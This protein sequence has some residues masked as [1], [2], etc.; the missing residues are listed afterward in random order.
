MGRAKKLLLAAGTL[1]LIGGGVFYYLNSKDHYDPSKYSATITAPEINSQEPVSPI[2]E[3]DAGA[4]TAAAIGLAKGM[5]VELTLPDQFDVS[6]TIAPEIETLI[7]AFSK[8]AGA[9]VRGFLDKEEE[10]FLAQ[11]KA[12]FIADISPIPVVIRNTLALPKLRKS[13]YPVMLIYEEEMAASLRNDAHEDQI[14]VVT[15]QSYVVQDIR[16]LAD[17]AGLASIF[18][19]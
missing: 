2:V 15:I 4:P 6:H 13:S 7:F 3:R 19:R 14:A 5:R 11:H 18:S 16:Y 17:E 10:N 8:G 9:T 12:I 1:V